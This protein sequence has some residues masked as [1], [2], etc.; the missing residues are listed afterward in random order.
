MAD[1]ADRLRSTANDMIDPK[2]K[3]MDRWDAIR[4][5]VETHKGSDLPRLMFES[6][7]EDF[8]ELMKEAAETIDPEIAE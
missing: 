5:T 3:V 1:L 2:G 8:A 6:L 4:G 7:M